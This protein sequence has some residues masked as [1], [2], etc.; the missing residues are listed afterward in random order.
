ML[1]SPRTP[2]RAAA[3]VL[4]LALLAAGAVAVP[5]S[6]RADTVRDAQMWVLDAV[7]APSAWSVTRGQGATVAVIDSGVNPAVSDLAGSVTTG[8]DLPGCTPR[9]ATPTGVCTEPGWPR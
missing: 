5:A 4:M 9:R 1:N 3:S 2:R 7:S 6:A 8:P